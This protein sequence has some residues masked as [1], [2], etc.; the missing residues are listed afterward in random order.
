MR[1]NFNKSKK[2]WKENNWG[3][4]LV[5]SVLAGRIFGVP[6]ALLVL[7]GMTFFW[8]EKAF[9]WAF[10][11]GLFLDLFSGEHMGTWSLIFLLLSLGV[12]LLRKLFLPV[13]NRLDLP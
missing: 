10:G 7:L 11:V 5:V 13:S 12:V 6:L 3:L 9:P 8:R 4:A 2:F 1:K